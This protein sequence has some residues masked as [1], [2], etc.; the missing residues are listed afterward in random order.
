MVWNVEAGYNLDWGK[1]LEIVLKYAA[2]DEAEVGGLPETR[3]GLCLN[4][5]I[6][7]DVVVSLGYLYDEFDEDEDLDGRDSRNL[8]F[9]Q[10]AI[11]F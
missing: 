7:E 9:A 3:Y 10:L 4:Q 1:N 5:D 2:S 11:E 6:F 8:A